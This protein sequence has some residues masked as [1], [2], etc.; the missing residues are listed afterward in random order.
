MAHLLCMGLMANENSPGD[1][2]NGKTL[3]PYC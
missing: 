3:C 2:L 1:Q